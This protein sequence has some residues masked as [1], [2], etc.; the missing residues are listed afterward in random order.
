M[1]Y[2]TKNDMSRSYRFSLSL[3]F[4]LSIFLFNAQDYEILVS[5]RGENAVKMYDTDGN[6]MS[7]FVEPGTGGLNTT[8]DILFHPDGTVLVSG[9][10]NTS[11]KRYDGI[12]GDYIEDF[13]SGYVLQSPSKMEIGPDN[14]IYITQWGGNNVKTVRFDL[15]GNF[16]DEFTSIATPRGLGQVWDEDGNYYVAL[17]SQTGAD[18]TV[19]KFD[20]T[21]N[22]IETFINSNVLQ[23]PTHIWWDDNGDMLVNDWTSGVVRR[24]D[25]NG[26]Y[27]NDF[28]TGMINPEGI[29]FLPNGDLLIGDWGN[30]AVRRISPGG[31][32]IGIFAVGNGLEDPNSVRVRQ[33]PMVNVEEFSDEGFDVF[34]NPNNGVFSINANQVNSYSVYDAIGRIVSS[35]SLDKGNSNHQISVKGLTEG[36]YTIVLNGENL[37]KRTKLI[38][39]L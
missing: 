12:S 13:S 19:E 17:Y 34:P 9:F 22:H 5:S 16:V 15:S 39:A 26:N 2:L 11:I 27:I 38:I 14:L 10:N 3:L 24:Y 7:N 20:G 25:S 37:I 35:G 30:D 18:G 23:G 4:S 36:N 6:F 29:A 28:V 21:G 31:S 8:E 32:I 33:S 1:N